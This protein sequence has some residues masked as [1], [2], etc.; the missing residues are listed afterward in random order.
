MYDNAAGLLPDRPNVEAIYARV[1]KRKK[2]KD[3][4]PSLNSVANGGSSLDEDGPAPPVPQGPRRLFIIR[5]AERV[6]VTF[7]KQWIQLSFD[8]DGSYRR[9]NLNMPKEIPKRKGGP[10]DFLKDSPVTETGFFQARLTGEGIKEQGIRLTHVFSSPALRCVQTADA[11]LRGLHDP[12]VKIKVENGLFEWL[13]WCRGGF[14]T[15]MV[16][17]ELAKC[18]LQVCEGVRV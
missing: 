9:R 17:S 10:S 3:P 4:L 7:G 6:D 8:P 13:A 2:S 12:T 14:P 16:P 15:F 18:G 11:I 5:H 1:Q